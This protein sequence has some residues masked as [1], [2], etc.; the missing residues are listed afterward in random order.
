MSVVI[1]AGAGCSVAAP[2]SLPGWFDLNDAILEALWDRMA[3][4]NLPN[5]I[6]GDVLGHIKSKR[7]QYAFPPDYQAQVMVERVGMKYFELLTVVDSDVYN[8]IHH[9]TAEGARAGLVK[10]VVTTNFDRNFERAFAEARVPFRAFID[11]PGFNAFER[12]PPG[13]I[14]VIKIHGCCS[15]PESMVDT[16]RQRLKGRAKSPAT[17]KQLL[18]RVRAE[19]ESNVN[20]LVVDT[21]PVFEPELVT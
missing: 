16:R 3:P 14:P 19:I 7:K 5:R 10:A 13:E 15:S 12:R 20:R 17:D 9:Y 6:R 2:A 18:L 4:Y 21:I 8:A 11:E 1:F